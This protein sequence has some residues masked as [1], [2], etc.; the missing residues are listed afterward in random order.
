MIIPLLAMVIICFLW[1]KGGDKDGSIRDIPVP[2]ILALYFAFTYKL[3]W[4][5][6]TVGGTAQMIR[7]GYGNYDPE[8]DDKPSL[9]ASWLKDRQGKYIRMVWGFIVSLMIGSSLYIVGHIGLG[10]YLFYIFYNVLINFLVCHLK[11]SRLATDILVG[12]GI[13][14]IVFLAY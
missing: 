14:S 2:I 9:L 13:S 8:H 10:Y 5:F 7:L 4:L 11:F 12:V 1:W 3:W 6:I